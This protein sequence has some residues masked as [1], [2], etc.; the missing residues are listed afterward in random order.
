MVKIIYCAI[1]IIIIICK[2][3]QWFKV[4]CDPLKKHKCQVKT[5]LKEI[6]VEVAKKHKDQKLIPGNKICCKCYKEFDLLLHSDI[7][8]GVVI[9]EVEDE[10]YL[11]EKL[12]KSLV[13]LDCTPIKK[14]RKIE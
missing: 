13:H 3:I 14:V 12:N 10:V 4:C 1:T 2:N 7:L 9:Y 11:D 5:K 6:T 8:A